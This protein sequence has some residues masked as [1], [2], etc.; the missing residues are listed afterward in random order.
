MNRLKP[1][2]LVTPLVTLCQAAAF[3]KAGLAWSV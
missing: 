2:E 3:P 1:P